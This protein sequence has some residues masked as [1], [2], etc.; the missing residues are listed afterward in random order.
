MSDPHV[1][2]RDR[3]DDRVQGAATLLSRMDRDRLSP[4]EVGS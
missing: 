2:I 4:K 3:G 1:T